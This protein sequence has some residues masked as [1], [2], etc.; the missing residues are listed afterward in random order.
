MGS[1]VDFCNFAIRIDEQIVKALTSTA[2]DI[3]AK[4]PDLNAGYGRIDVNKA[5]DALLAG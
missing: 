1:S 3:D 4:G 5:I 2:V